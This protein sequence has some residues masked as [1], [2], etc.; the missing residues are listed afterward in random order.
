MSSWADQIE[1]QDQASEVSVEGEVCPTAEGPTTRRHTR[2]LRCG[3]TTRSRSRTCCSPASGD[4]QGAAGDGTHGVV[5]PTETLD[6]AGGGTQSVCRQTEP[7][8]LWTDPLL[9][10][11]YHEQNRVKSMSA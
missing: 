6:V 9:W 7:I 1:A 8:T 4:V 3:M 5:W 11:M 2:T 10:H